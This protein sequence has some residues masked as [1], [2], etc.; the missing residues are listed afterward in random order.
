MCIRDSINAEYMGI[1]INEPKQC[2]VSISIEKT[3]TMT[4]TSREDCEPSIFWTIL[5][6]LDEEL[7]K[8][9]AELE[10]SKEEL[11]R[12]EDELAQGVG[13][14]LNPPIVLEDL[15]EYDLS[16]NVNSLLDL[17]GEGWKVTSGDGYGNAPKISSLV[18]SLFGL[19]KTGKTYILNLLTTLK[20]LCG[21]QVQSQSLH[22]TS[23]YQAEKWITYIDSSC[24]GVPYRNSPTSTNKDIKE[25]IAAREITELFLSNFLFDTSDVILIVV[26]KLTR[27]DQRLLRNICDKYKNQEVVVIHNLQNICYVCYAED[28][29]G[30]DIINAFPVQQ[31]CVSE[32][33]LGPDG[34]SQRIWVETQP[35]RNRPI[36]HVVMAREGTEAGA[37]YNTSCLNYIKK[38]LHTDSRSRKFDLVGDLVQYAERSLNDY[39]FFENTKRKDS[40]LVYNA[41]LGSLVLEEGFVSKIIDSRTDNILQISR[42][43]LYK[44]IIISQRTYEC[45]SIEYTGHQYR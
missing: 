23:C 34:L 33:L 3:K 28:I 41:K 8:K 15:N 1:F 19:P 40:S 13:P 9:K 37:F 17:N 39:V 38:V 36:T 16:I 25:S 6:A 43:V 42:R 45:I 5:S 32:I 10:S 27:M 20:Y 21:L 30:E 22:Q 7:S 4:T 18:V 12:R 29:I 26:G 31:L 35:S 24:Y 2:R 44:G 14:N 11:K